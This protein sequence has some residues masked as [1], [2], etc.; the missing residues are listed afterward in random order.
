MNACHIIGKVDPY[1][2]RIC[3][4]WFDM[5]GSIT[6]ASTIG[7]APD[8]NHPDGSRRRMF[9]TQ[10]PCKFVGVI[11]QIVDHTD[12]GRFEV[13][14]HDHD[15][16]R[17]GGLYDPIVSAWS[18]DSYHGL[19]PREQQARHRDRRMDTGIDIKD[20]TAYWPEEAALKDTAWIKYMADFRNKHFSNQ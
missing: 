10:P 13:R 19:D 5:R 11:A 4:T 7:P 15:G 3:K 9:T 12:T 8:F 1:L 14:Y 2:A 16:V 20:G 18:T 6:S 17:L